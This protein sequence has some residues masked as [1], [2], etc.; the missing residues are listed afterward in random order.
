MKLYWN[1]MLMQLKSQMQYRV[2]FFLTVFGQ[3]I[4]AFTSFFGLYFI[5]EQVE[6]IDGFTFG[7]VLI[8]FAVILMSFSIG[9]LFGGGLAVF[10]RLLGDGTFDRVLVRPR[11]ALLQVL[12]M[13]LDFTRIG[14]LLQAVVTLCIAVPMSG[15]VWSAEKVMVFIL[16]IFSGSVLFFSLFLIQAA[17]AFFTTESL[18]FLDFFTYGA[19]QFG[20]YPF[21]VYGEG[22]L[23]V[24]TFVV[25]LALVQYYPMLYLTDS[26]TALYAFAPIAALL[27]FV[28]A[29]GLFR[30][31][32]RRFKSTGS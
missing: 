3:F 31:G 12:V 16:M 13:H 22:I 5:C 17:C 20:R 15:I 21:S 6:A 27:F 30:L 9:E 1:M 26:G 14:L 19:R 32:V 28:P 2:S 7:Q 29:M 4:T 10:A 23:R 25:P 18:K 8:C 24:L 11:G